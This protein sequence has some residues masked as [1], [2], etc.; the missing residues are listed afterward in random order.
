MLTK[1][2]RNDFEK[3]IDWAYNLALDITRSSYPTYTDGI[4]TKQ[5]FIDAALKTFESDNSEILLFSND[6]KILGWINYYVLPEDKYIALKAFNTESQTKTALKEFENYCKSRFCRYTL[7]MGFAKEN[8]NA[9]SY[10]KEN[11]Y[12][13]LEVSF[14]NVFHFSDFKPSDSSDK[15]MKITKENYCLF[16]ELHRLNDDEMYWNTE[17]ILNKIDNWNIYYYDDGKYQGA[18][19]F[20]GKKTAEIF[21]V[22]FSDNEYNPA[23]FKELFIKCLNVCFSRKAEHLYYFSEYDEGDI[24]K[25]LGFISLGEYNLYT[26]YLT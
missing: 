21:G 7:Y 3:Y 20:T 9:I 5:D 24:L 17:R 14:P 22:D 2:E 25:K 23:V 6:E 15:I 16:S 19:Y 11:N 12:K 10:F 8:V 13:L 18:I 1:L 4:K 26:L